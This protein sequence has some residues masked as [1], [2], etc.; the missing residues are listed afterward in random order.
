[1]KGVMTHTFLYEFAGAF[2]LGMIFV[3]LFRTLARRTGFMSRPNPIVQT[4]KKPVAYLGGAGVFVSFIALFLIIARAS[5]FS[6]VFAASVALLVILGTLDDFKPLRWWQKLG[7][8]FAIAGASLPLM[9]WVLGIKIHPLATAV[10]VLVVVIVTN[11]FNVLDVSD[12]LA[13]SAGAIVSLGLFAAFV[14]SSPESGLSAAALIL[15]G[16]LL[17]FLMFNKHPASI[18]LGD[19]GSLPLGFA[20]GVL[21]VIWLLSKP[22][23]V[24]RLTVFF[25]LLSGVLFEIALVSFHRI[26]RGLS[27]FRGSPDHFALRLVRAGWRVPM[28]V[29]VSTIVHLFLAASVALLLLPV[30]ATYV[31]LGVLA[32]FYLTSFVLLSRIKVTS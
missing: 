1:M 8:E 7:I 9:L 6:L 26:K 30:F 31:Y 24:T 13:A 32:A 15:A 5:V 17:G 14:I 2:A 22:V 18:Y 19:G 20:L 12:G 11:G 21:G 27:P 16:T 10:G 29:A 3:W 4:H 25:S 23:D 28:I